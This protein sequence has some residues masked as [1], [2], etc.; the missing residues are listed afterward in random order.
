MTCPVSRVGRRHSEQRLA[1]VLAAIA[2]DKPAPHDEDPRDHE[3]A[4]EMRHDPETDL[5]AREDA[6]EKWLDRHEGTR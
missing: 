1:D 3:T 2:E 6:Y 4:W 5:E